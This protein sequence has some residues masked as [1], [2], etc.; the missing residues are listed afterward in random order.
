MERVFLLFARCRSLSLKWRKCAQNGGW[1]FL[2]RNGDFSRRK[3]GRKTRA[4][5]EAAIM[6]YNIER[7]S[8]HCKM[9]SWSGERGCLLLFCTELYRKVGDFWWGGGGL[10]QTYFMDFFK[11]LISFQNWAWDLIKC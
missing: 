4:R 9:F 8:A 6:F 10:V 2:G 1:D 3:R 7:M 5:I 11:S